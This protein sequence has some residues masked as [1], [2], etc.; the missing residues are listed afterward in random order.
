MKTKAIIIWNEEN[1]VF[2]HVMKK[3]GW[4]GSEKR[5]HLLSIHIF[6]SS[7]EFWVLNKNYNFWQQPVW[8]R[9]SENRQMNNDSKH[10]LV[11]GVIVEATINI[12]KKD[13]LL[14]YFLKIFLMTPGKVS[15]SIKWL[16]QL[17]HDLSFKF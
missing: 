3:T 13:I 4:S 1:T 14:T 10:L 15:V 8:K 16:I 17:F 5:Q 11:N 9:P 7:F 2:L 6:L 12:V